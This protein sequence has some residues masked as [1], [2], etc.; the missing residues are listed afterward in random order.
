MSEK[1]NGL[2]LGKLEQAIEGIG[3]EL[4][5]IRQDNHQEHQEIKMSIKEINNRVTNLGLWKTQ[6]MSAVVVIS[7]IINIVLWLLKDKLIKGL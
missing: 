1:E 7:L 4:D 3:K 6:V 2:F 5:L